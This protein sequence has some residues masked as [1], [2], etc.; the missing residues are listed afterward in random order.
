MLLLIILPVYRY[1]SLNVINRHI[2]VLKTHYNLFK[3]IENYEICEFYVKCNIN[4]LIYC[5]FTV[6]TILAHFRVLYNI[7]T[8]VQHVNMC[9]CHFAINCKMSKSWKWWKCHISEMWGSDFDPQGP[10]GTL[11]GPSRGTPTNGAF[12]NGIL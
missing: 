7:Y 10:P 9:I 5:P 11:E 12:I 1:T 2:N 8:N 3:N 4:T 6:C